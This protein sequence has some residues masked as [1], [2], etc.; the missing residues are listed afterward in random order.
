MGRSITPTYRVEYSDNDGVQR[1]PFAKSMGWNGKSA[2]RA[3]QANLQKWRDTFNASFERG[4]VNEHIST[5][6]GFV[7]RIGN[8]RIVEQATD[9]VVATFTAPAFEAA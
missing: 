8:C 3:T 1:R 9:R 7:V 5:A 6:A 4:G 2:G